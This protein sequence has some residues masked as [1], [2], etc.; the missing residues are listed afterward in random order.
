MTNFIEISEKITILGN[1]EKKNLKTVDFDRF[2][3]Q[4][5]PQKVI[6]SPKPSKNPG[7]ETSKINCKKLTAISGPSGLQ[8]CMKFCVWSLFEWDF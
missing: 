3:H 2:F 4:K 5:W 1:F 7:T 6:K 8:E